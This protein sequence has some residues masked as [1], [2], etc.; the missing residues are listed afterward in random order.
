MY[1]KAKK[2]ITKRV[3]LDLKLIQSAIKGLSTHFEET[4]KGSKSLIT[5]EGGYI[6]INVCMSEVPMIST[7]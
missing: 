3:K 5:E 1:L 7:P 4:H 6:Y 2:R